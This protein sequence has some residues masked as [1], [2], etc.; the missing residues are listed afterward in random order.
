V[1][2]R[3]LTEGLAKKALKGRGEARDYLRGGVALVD[4]GTPAWSCTPARQLR[5]GWACVSALAPA[6]R[7]RAR[8]ARRVPASAT[9]SAGTPAPFAVAPRPVTH[10]PPPLRS[11]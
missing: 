8:G 10:S 3:V 4:D 7:D 9:T 1:D 6:W 2:P 5:C 11:L